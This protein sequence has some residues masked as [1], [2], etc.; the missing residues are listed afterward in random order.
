MTKTQHHQTQQ[1]GKTVK[2][3]GNNSP[4]SIS[5]DISDL[6]SQSSKIDRKFNFQEVIRLNNNENE[7]NQQLNKQYE[8]LNEQIRDIINAPG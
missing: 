5:S 2:N 8:N 7:Q 3:T 6:T 4:I 1:A